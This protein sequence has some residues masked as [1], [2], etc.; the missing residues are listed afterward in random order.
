VTPRIVTFCTAEY[1][2]VARN[3]LRALAE[4]GLDGAA[5]IVAL[6]AATRAA[7]PP[8]RVLH[9]PLVAASGDLGALWAHR[10]G[11]LRDVLASGEALIHS[12]ADAIWLRDPRPDIAACDAAMVFSQGTIWPPDIHRRHGLVLCCGFFHLRPN[13][14][15]LAFLDAVAARLETDRD[16]QMAVNR[17]VAEW[18]DGWEI[19]DPYEIPFGQDRFIASRRPIAARGARSPA[20][21]IGIA[22][23]P[24]HA[25]PRLL[26]SVSGE[27]VVAHP[28]SAKTPDDKMRVL[29]R[30]GL[31]RS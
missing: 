3:W 20:G 10:I 22:V 19:D 7:F 6:D 26:D 13:P 12:D 8:D 1:V 18:I 2:P 9:R 28:L 23:L 4:I 30:F 15:V 31:W 21:K 17:V 29:D 24:H 14:Q 11:V 5:T 27:T 16:D 25:Y